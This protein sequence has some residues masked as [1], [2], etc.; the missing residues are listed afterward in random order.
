MK[1]VIIQSD[2]IKA[3]KEMIL[4]NVNENPFAL[5]YQLELLNL[6]ICNSIA[7]PPSAR[8]VW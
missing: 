2:R 6:Y 5:Q 8:R 3:T 1:K 7:T 4:F